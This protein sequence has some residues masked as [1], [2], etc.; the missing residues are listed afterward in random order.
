MQNIEFFVRGGDGHLLLWVVVMLF[1][2]AAC[3][4]L[5]KIPRCFNVLRAIREATTRWVIY[6]CDTSSSASVCSL[7]SQ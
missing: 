6:E 1:V 4:C 7:H 5:L 2:N 3:R